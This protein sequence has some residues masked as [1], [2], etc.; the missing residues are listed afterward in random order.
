MFPV[1]SS[2]FCPLLPSARPRPPRHTPTN[3]LSVSVPTCVVLSLQGWKNVSDMSLS[4]YRLSAG[5]RLRSVSPSVAAAACPPSSRFQLRLKCWWPS[6]FGVR[7]VLVRLKN[8]FL[9]FG[10]QYGCIKI[11]RDMVLKMPRPDSGLPTS[12]LINRLKSTG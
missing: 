4:Q 3:P 2:H 8:L 5:R 9:V 11:T 12:L 6:Q 1:F 10:K 7:S